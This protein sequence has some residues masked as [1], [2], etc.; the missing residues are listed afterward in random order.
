M[1][2]NIAEVQIIARARKMYFINICI[3]L[4][5]GNDCVKVKARIFWTYVTIFMFPLWKA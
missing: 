3:S 4:R 1:I 5:V 2:L